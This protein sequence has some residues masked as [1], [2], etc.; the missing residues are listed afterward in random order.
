LP[1][2]IAAGARAAAER[3]EVFDIDAMAASV[4]G[5]VGVSVGVGVGGVGVG[6]G[7]PALPLVP[8]PVKETFFD[9]TFFDDFPLE[10]LES[11]AFMDGVATGANPGGESPCLAPEAVAAA[12]EE[13]EEVVEAVPSVPATASQPHASPGLKRR[14]V[15]RMS[16]G[17]AVAAAVGV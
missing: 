7:P 12:V 10:W 16:G 14:L 15:V 6:G 4:G 3:R 2:A 8:L 9:A 17:A 13:E 1:T 5:G 11:V